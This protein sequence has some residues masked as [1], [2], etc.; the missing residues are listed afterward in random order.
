MTAE[1]AQTPRTAITKKYLHDKYPQPLSKRNQLLYYM[2]AA[3]LYALDA[4]EYERELAHRAA[5]GLVER[6]QKFQYPNIGYWW[7]SRPHSKLTKASNAVE[8]VSRE[9]FNELLKLANEAAA[10]LGQKAGWVSV[11]ERLP[12]IGGTYEVGGYR[13]EAPHFFDREYCSFYRLLDGPTWQAH[14]SRPLNFPI[15]FWHDLI[16]APAG[17]KEGT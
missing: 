2:E 13:T 8:V 4:H 12:E 11:K 9:D 14:N 16:P 5:P 1:P 7:A 17:E 15:Q 6:L 3:E 10:I